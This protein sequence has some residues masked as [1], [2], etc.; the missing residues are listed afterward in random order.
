MA[1]DTSSVSVGRV[2]ASSD[3]SHRTPGAEDRQQQVELVDA[4]P[5]RRAAALDV[6]VSA[7]R[8]REVRRHPGTRACCTRRPAGDRSSRRR[9]PDAAGPHR[10]RS[11]AGTRRRP[12]LRSRAPPR[13]PRRSR[14]ATAP[15][16]SRR[17]EP[18]PPRSTAAASGR[19]EP[20]GRA[21]VHEVGLLGGEHVVDGCVHSRNP[22]RLG[23]G[24]G[25]V[26]VDVDDGGHLGAS[27]QSADA[28][29]VGDGDAA[30]SDDRGAIGH[31]SRDVQSGPE[32]AEV[33]Q[34]AAVPKH[35]VLGKRGAEER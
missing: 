18:T 27:A 6:P 12:A 24:A 32:A 35:E 14:R 31:G 25:T 5:H 26:E 17:A 28:F 20:G 15:A 22:P 23:E 11:A 16:A 10:T 29:D 2:L 21:D 3:G 8:N 19:W 9:R 4:V 30:G 13:W 1:A 33:K 7:P 34:R